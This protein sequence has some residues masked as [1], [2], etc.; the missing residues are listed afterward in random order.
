MFPRFFH[1]VQGP[2]PPVTVG[3]DFGIKNEGE[4]YSLEDSLILPAT[5]C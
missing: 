3:S 1:W 2:S 5:R 4:H